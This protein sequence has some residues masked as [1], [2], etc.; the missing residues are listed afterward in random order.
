MGTIHLFSLRFSCALLYSLWLPW[1][2]RRSESPFPPLISS[3]ALMPGL[4][5]FSN[6][7][8]N[9]PHS[10]SSTTTTSSPSRPRSVTSGASLQLGLGKA[11]CVALSARL[12]TSSVAIPCSPTFFTSWLSRAHWVVEVRATRRIRLS[13]LSVCWGGRLSSVRAQPFRVFTVW[14]DELTSVRY[15]A[16]FLLRTWV[17]CARN[18]AV[19]IVLGTPA[20]AI[21]ILDCVRPPH[22]LC[23]NK[24]KL[25]N[26]HRRFMSPASAATA[27][28]RSK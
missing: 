5:A 16:T 12:Y 26:N 7:R 8:S 13:V 21:F 10:R 11:V 2:R 17:V 6:T 27:P 9:H 28:R 14:I 4:L 18:I 1:R 15:L 3:H 20:L 23:L 25:T 22:F 24:V 19:L